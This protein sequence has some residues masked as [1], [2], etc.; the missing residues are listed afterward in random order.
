MSELTNTEKNFLIDNVDFNG[1]ILWLNA[2][3]LANED[4]S[5]L[6]IK[7]DELNK[8]LNRQSFAIKSLK[9]SIV[10]SKPLVEN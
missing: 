9:F 2:I 4:I 3:K 6:D 7:N 5:A 10:A 1:F 8:I